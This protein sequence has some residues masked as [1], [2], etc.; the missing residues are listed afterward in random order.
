MYMIITS[1]PEW[2]ETLL[3][4]A[5]QTMMIYRSD[6]VRD[7]ADLQ[8]SIDSLHKSLAHAVQQQDAIYLM[9]S[10]SPA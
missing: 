3:I 1:D 7:N 2:Y 5:M 4:L 8:A 10:E 9:Q 6:Q